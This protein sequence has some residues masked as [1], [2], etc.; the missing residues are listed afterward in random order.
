MKRHGSLLSVVLL[1]VGMLF[2]S[3]QP[4]FGAN[5][6][7]SNDTQVCIGCHAPAH[8]GIVAGWEKGRMARVTPMAARSMVSKKRRVSFEEV[9]DRLARVVVG[10][11]ECHTL[12]PEKHKDTFEHNGFQVHVVVTPEDCATCHPVEVQQYGRNIMSHAH[13]NLQNNLVY[14]GLT[15]SV[16]GAHSLAGTRVSIRPGNEQTDA[17]SCLYCHGTVVE[18]KGTEARETNHGEMTFPVLSG[19]PNQ[20]VGRI[21]PDGSMGSCAACHTRHQFSIEMAR[22]PNTCS[23]CHKGPDVP[24]YPVYEVSKHGNIYSALGKGKTWDFNAVPWTVGKDFTAPTCAVC[25]VSLIVSEEGDVVADRTHQMN[26]RAAWRLF[27]LIYA[28]PHPKSPDTTTIKNKAGLPLPTEL[29][30]EPVAEYLIDAEEQ[31]K[32]RKNMQS[33]C[34][35]CHSQGW[36]DGQFARM[37]NTVQTTNEM[38]LAATQ[39]LLSAWDKGAAKGLAQ[40]DSIFNE[41]IEKKWVEQWLFFANSTRFAS[42]MMGADYGVFANGRWYMSKNVLEMSDWLEFKLKK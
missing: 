16:N 7:I 13:G 2:L 12:N 11:A 42:A 25:H 23:E 9:P 1:A 26:D 4:V 6:H 10:C 37:E 24:A 3:S 19:W 30:G 18:V 39:I 36:V 40:K 17:D 33:I 14:R 20:G 21:N 8:P 27:G 31:D 35:A 28:H 41:A 29:T 38:T 34:L 22:K 32:R 5:E 15:E